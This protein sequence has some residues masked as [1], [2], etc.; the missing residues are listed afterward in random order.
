MDPGHLTRATIVA[1]YRATRPLWCINDS[2]GPP[3]LPPPLWKCTRVP[4]TGVSIIGTMQFRDSYR[5]PS[6]GSRGE[7]GRIT[8]DKLGIL[9]SR[10][11]PPCVQS[12][13]KYRGRLVNFANFPF[14]SVVDGQFPWDPPLSH[15]SS[16]YMC[17]VEAEE[18]KG[19]RS[20]F[21]KRRR[22]AERWKGM[23]KYVCRM[24]EGFLRG[25]LIRFLGKT[26]E[27]LL[28]KGCSIKI[29]I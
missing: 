28:L 13:D 3:S 12:L 23:E 26:C 6:R 27:F 9:P 11:N 5:G 19:R 22:E 21:V 18:S 7:E 4:A 15:P 24:T 16:V 17:R 8:S 25:S 10:F 1:Q 29:N 14:N 20:R 2:Q